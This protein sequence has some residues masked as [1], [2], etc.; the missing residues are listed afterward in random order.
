MFLCVMLNLSQVSRVQ[1]LGCA[2]FGDQDIGGVTHADC[3][4][5]RVNQFVAAFHVPDADTP[6]VEV[7]CEAA[8][9][10]ADTSLAQQLLRV[11]F[12]RNYYDTRDTWTNGFRCSFSFYMSQYLNIHSSRIASIQIDNIDKQTEFS[13]VT[14]RGKITVGFVLQAATTGEDSASLLPL[15]DR[16]RLLNNDDPV[17]YAFTDYN[18]ETV[19]V[20]VVESS[21]VVRDDDDSAAVIGMWTGIALAI[22]ICLVLLALLLSKKKQPSRV[23]SDTQKRASKASV[24]A[25][26][27][28]A[29][30]GQESGAESKAHDSKVVTSQTSSDDATDTAST[31][32][33]KS[34]WKRRRQVAQQAETDA[35]DNETTAMPVVETNVGQAAD[36]DGKKEKQE[37]PTEMED[38]T[39]PAPAPVVVP[40]KFVPRSGPQLT[41]PS[42]AAMS[43][44]DAESHDEAPKRVLPKPVVMPHKSNMTTPSAWQRPRPAANNPFVSSPP[45]MPS[46]PNRGNTSRLPS[47]PPNGARGAPGL[48][49]RVKIAPLPPRPAAL[50]A[51]QTQPVEESDADETS[52]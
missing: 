27:L 49:P 1:L 11:T 20:V 4:C 9:P 24:D 38:V 37:N 32:K 30:K 26:E 51:V 6:P 17:V 28:D 12:F 18:I 21:A 31:P 47:L 45:S 2:F 23:R 40:K 7:G 46:F 52:V 5:A 42:D 41:L 10:E 35:S 25:I 14:G 33:K 50:P 34:F 16:L 13:D 8:L 48:M 3:R 39:E 19:D 44:S 22:I 36:T 43:L 15:V 29:L